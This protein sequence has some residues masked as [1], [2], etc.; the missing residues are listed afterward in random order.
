MKGLSIKKSTVAKKLRKEFTN[1]LQQDILEPEQINLK[2]VLDKYDEIAKNIETSLQM[3]MTEYSIPKN[4][5]IIESY[6]TPDTIEGVRAVLTWNA[7]E[8]EN[9]IVPPEKINMLKL[10]CPS[11]DDPR[12]EALKESQPD[13]YDAIMR[14]VFKRDSDNSTQL[15]FSRF[16]FSA[17]A[18]PKG[19]ERIPEYLLPFIDY[20]A[21]VNNN[22]TNGY[23]LLESL[24]VMI[25][26]VNTVKYKSN[27]VSI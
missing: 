16:G 13:K 5:E 25:E 27:I 11:P 2:N 4:V 22:L 9:Q 8:P 7:L 18:I 21:M 1:I 12:L 19:V 10:D 20:K 15:D 24:G 26:E 6:K 17:I 23:I 14:V 3:G